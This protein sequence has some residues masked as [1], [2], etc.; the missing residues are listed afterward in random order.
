ME[1][2][3]YPVAGIVNS[4]HQFSYENGIVVTCVQP[5]LARGELRAGPDSINP[6]GMIHGGA[7]ATLADT[8]A[9]CCA[10]SK[11]GNC[12]TAS[13]SMEFLRPAQGDLFCE[14]T[15]KKLGRQLS[16]IQITITNAGGKTVA[17][18]TFSFFMARPRDECGIPQSFASQMPA[19]A[20]K[21]PLLKGGGPPDAVRWRGDSVFCRAC[22]IPLR[23]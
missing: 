5:G 19:S 20:E 3:I 22:F 9:G 8:V 6:H 17:A 7:M 12:V 23:G 13:S 10:C 4:P 15:P 16:V 2:K 21:P 1:E 14:A 18:G 11:G